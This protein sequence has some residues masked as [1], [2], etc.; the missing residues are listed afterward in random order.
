MI[1]DTNMSKQPPISMSRRFRKSFRKSSV[2]LQGL[3]EGAVHDLV[4][5]IREQPKSFKRKRGRLAHLPKVLEIDV[6]GAHRLLAMHNVAEGLQLLD[7]G[8]HDVVPRYDSSKLFLDQKQ[9]LSVPKTFWPE[10]PDHAL[11]FFMAEP[12][13]TYSEF[14]TE[15]SR[16]WLY[17]LSDQQEEV[18][19][20][21]TETF[22]DQIERNHVPRPTFIV[23]GPGTGKTSILINLLKELTDLGISTGISI[24]DKM[25]QFIEAFL[26]EIEVQRFLCDHK[27]GAEFQCCLLDDPGNAE[28]IEQWLYHSRANG[29]AIVVAF[30]PCQLDTYDP[31][32]RESGISDEQFLLICDEFDVDPYGLTVCYRQKENVGKAAKRTMDSIARSTPFLNDRKIEEFQNR[33]IELTTLANTMEYPNPNGYCQVHENSDVETIESEITR[34]LEKP[35]WSHWPPLLVVLDKNYPKDMIELMTAIAKLGD[36]RYRI[37]FL[38]QAE[39][40]K[41]LEFQHV[42]LFLGKNL[43]DEL[44]N[45]FAGSGQAE[46]ANRRLARIPFS[47]A[48]DSMVVFVE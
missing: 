21:I 43:F 28:E 35:L 38:D 2:K 5:L 41:G 26:P 25:V 42:F 46:Y 15:Q 18:V 1:L 31:K 36:N 6:T 11:R 13:K 7:V 33:H 34:I 40:V 39:A 44:E 9:R 19:A 22:F 10:G 3:I 47:R 8:D 4:N 45:E 17:F 29:C 14:G 48:K 30:D 37:A 16:D 20:E 23:G 32:R 12:C 27:D 24:N